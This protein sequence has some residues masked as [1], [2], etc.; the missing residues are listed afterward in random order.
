MRTKILLIGLC[1]LVLLSSIVSADLNVSIFNPMNMTYYNSSLA[2]NWH[3]NETLD[4][5]GYS[6]DQGDNNTLKRRDG[7]YNNTYY[8]FSSVMG[9]LYGIT[10]NNTYFW[11]VQGLNRNVVHKFYM[12]G[13]YTYENFTI[14]YI[15]STTRVRGIDNNETHLFIVGGDYDVYIYEMDGTYVSNFSIGFDNGTSLFVS[16]ATNNSKIWVGDSAT[17]VIYKYDMDGNYESNITGTSQVTG[18]D[19][20]NESIWVVSTTPARVTKYN[21][22]GNATLNFTITN[23]TNPRGITFNDTYFWITDYILGTL[24]EY[25]KDQMFNTTLNISRGEHNITVCANSTDLNFSCTTHLFT[26]NLTHLI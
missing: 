3:A 14:D 13:T 12:N 18:I 4:W 6:L 23:N 7:L 2:L 22:S 24:N 26:V 1:M 16:I 8:N 5:A 11:A 9:N 15:T 10:T 20:E 17:N 19:A 21:A 25:E